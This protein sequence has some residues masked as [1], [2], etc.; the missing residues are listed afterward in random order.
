MLVKSIQYEGEMAADMTVGERDVT[1][2]HPSCPQRECVTFKPTGRQQGGRHLY[3]PVHLLRWKR[4][5]LLCD[6][7]QIPYRK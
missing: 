5:M 6:L 7:L 3:F 2:L 1:V 4:V